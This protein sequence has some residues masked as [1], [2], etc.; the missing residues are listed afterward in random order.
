MGTTETII[1]YIILIYL[2]YKKKKCRSANTALSGGQKEKGK[3][4]FNQLGAIHCS[5]FTT[6]F[7]RFAHTLSTSG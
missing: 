6:S 3:K 1:N 7:E 2:I 5:Q 4:P